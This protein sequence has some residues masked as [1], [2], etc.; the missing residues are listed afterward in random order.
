MNDQEII[1]NHREFLEMLLSMCEKNLPNDKWEEMHTEIF[2]FL[3][4]E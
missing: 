2:E 4:P 1:A 3:N